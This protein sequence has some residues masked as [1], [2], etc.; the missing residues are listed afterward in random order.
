MSLAGRVA[1]ALGRMDRSVAVVVFTVPEKRLREMDLATGPC[2]P[3]DGRKRPL[4]GVLRQDGGEYPEQTAALYTALTGRSADGALIL[5]RQEG[6]GRLFQ[7]SQDFVD[8]M[9]D[10]NLELIRLS[11]EDDRRGDKELTSFA[12][13]Q[14]AI[15]RAWL[16][17]GGWPSSVVGTSNRLGRM[18]WAVTARDKGQPLYV[19]HG[20]RVPEY[21]VVSGRGPYPGRG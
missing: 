4:A 3:T 1:R 10:A 16:S 2:V 9:A 7:F 13:R 12:Q 21:V 17:L 6:Q 18:A 8:A 19:W 11:E 14:E 5:L 20:P 15:D